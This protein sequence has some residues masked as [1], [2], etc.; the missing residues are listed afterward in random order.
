MAY[1]TVVRALRNTLASA[2]LLSALAPTMAAAQQ[3]YSPD[4]L[5]VEDYAA[6]ERYLGQF[7]RP[8][9]SGGSVSP[10][11]IG[12]GSAFWYQSSLGDTPT[13]Y[14]V[15]PAAGTKQVAFNPMQIATAAAA[16]RGNTVRPNPAG[17]RILG[18]DID[19]GEVHLPDPQGAVACRLDA[20]SCRELPA[21]SRADAP[22]T[23]VV[24]PDGNWAAFQRDW[25]L[26]VT[27]LRTGSE[28]Q[29]T[30]GGTEDWGWGT[31]NAGWTRSDRPVL[32]WSPD[33]RK[34][35]TFRHDARGVSYMHMVNTQVGAPRLESWRYPFPEDSVIFRIERVVIDVPS[36]D[37]VRLDMPVDQ[38]R[39]TICDH[40]Y[41]NGTFSD[42]EWRNGSE[43]LAFVSSSRDHKVAT[44]RVADP[45][46]G[47]VE[48]LFEERVETFFE[49]GNDNV[50]WS[51]MD[52]TDEFL[53]WSQESNWGHLYLHDL[54]T[55]ERIRQI[56]SGDWNVLQV[57]RVD[58]ENREIFFVGSGRE[59]GDPYF[60]YF[61]K[62]GI[63]DGRVTL[64]TPD[65]A[66]H[67]V[68]LSDDGTTIVDN[69]STPLI[70]QQ[71]A[72]R[73]TED[74]RVLV[75]LE[76]ADVSR[77][78]DSHW[79]API[80]FTT[81]ARDGVTDLYGIMYTPS[82][83]DPSQKYPVVNYLYPGPQSGSVG[84]RSFSPARRSHQALAELGFIVIEVDADDLGDIRA[85][86]EAQVLRAKL[87]GWAGSAVSG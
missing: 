20:S 61:Y 26:W 28:V 39:S 75:E 29:L 34:I 5:T 63:D 45:V 38:H 43:Q 53:W 8:L 86:H 11:W 65:S 3:P 76:Q 23:S 1:G 36:R 77:L 17:L 84:S 24:S 81:K 2:V 13:W 4:Q 50:N 48:T 33:S 22:R 70:P 6:A 64:L 37:L 79:K 16:F 12:E 30:E 10:N 78:Q 71:S 9:V 27:D 68:Q 56:T 72:V 54:N 46:S 67:S 87:P 83:M 21:D 66:H 42:V 85:G 80:P 73:S 49:S 7:M 62:V 35:A 51:V 44:F 82:H 41:C 19:A 14:I 32:L 58:E 60:E 59:P 74:G 52:D 40:I 69:W 55:G 25:N 31:N 18:I 47:A 15:D 57:R